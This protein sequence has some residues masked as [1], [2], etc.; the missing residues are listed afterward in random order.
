M[1]N[2]P[3]L[4]NKVLNNEKLSIKY[5]DRGAYS[6]GYTLILNGRKIFLKIIPIFNSNDKDDDCL[7]INLN[8]KIYN[9]PESFFYNEIKTQ[10]HVYKH[11]K[12]CPYIYDT[13]IL[14][15]EKNIKKDEND[16]IYF[17]NKLAIK[18]EKKNINYQILLNN[19]KTNEFNK[20]GLIFMSYMEYTNGNK[21]YDPYL[22]YNC[23]FGKYFLAK[24]LIEEI[25]EKKI[26]SVYL[27]III[28]IIHN[29][30]LLF[31]NG[32][33]HRDLHLGNIMIDR[34]E[35]IT[36][37]AYLKNGKIDYRYVGKVYII[38]YGNSVNEN[39]IN[40]Y[41]M[42]YI[43]EKKEK[44]NDFTDFNVEENKHIIE[45]IG[46]K[47]IKDGTNSNSELEN[48]WHIYDWIINL[49]FT[50]DY[51]INEELFIK[52]DVLLG[53]FEKGKNEFNEIKK[54]EENCCS[55]ISLFNF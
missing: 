22:T 36:K 53:E 5:T 45:L 41:K 4:L 3:E 9:V 37:Q 12:I 38:D 25:N 32:I 10:K 47:I 20:L 18:D 13:Y 17:I 16:I 51:N 1:I 52:F 2:I 19:L 30:I 54:Q 49:L 23:I 11:L 15:Y 33:M 35:I 28:Q 14:G 48:G 8:K 31:K 46:K 21:Y 42:E 27:F 7:Y 50:S 40:K 29:I 39:R 26:N 24:D 44:N 43:K 6:L 55:I 34:N